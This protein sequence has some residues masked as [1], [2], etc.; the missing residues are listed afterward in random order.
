MNTSLPNMRKHEQVYK[1]MEL[2]M[3]LCNFKEVA[4]TN[5]SIVHLVEQE[6]TDVKRAELSI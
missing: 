5:G 1:K 2:L 6:G 4:L 3:G